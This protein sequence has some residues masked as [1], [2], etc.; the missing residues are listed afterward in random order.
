MI[1]SLDILLGAFIA[2][3]AALK[4]YR[5]YQEYRARKSAWEVAVAGCWAAFFAFLAA[6]QFWGQEPVVQLIVSHL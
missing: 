5:A 6:R 4:V 2:F 3:M 1:R